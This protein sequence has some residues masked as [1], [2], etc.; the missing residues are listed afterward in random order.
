LRCR[1]RT[2]SYAAL[3]P[4]TTFA[5]SFFGVWSTGAAARLPWKV[6]PTTVVNMAPFESERIAGV[7]LSTSAEPNSPA[8]LR[9]ASLAP[10][11]AA[12]K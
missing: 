11:C 2:R 1:S 5:G 10:A 7:A 4:G 12:S 3:V 6:C 9:A 8:T